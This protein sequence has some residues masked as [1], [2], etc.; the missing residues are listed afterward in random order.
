MLAQI[1][2]AEGEA[3]GIPPGRQSH[4]PSKAQGQCSLDGVGEA[5]I[6]QA[7][8]GI[9]QQRADDHLQPI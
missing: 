9:V 6:H 1:G 5:G 8:H 2:N 7:Q 3:P 4:A